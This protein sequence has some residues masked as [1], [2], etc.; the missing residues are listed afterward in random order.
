MDVC[1]AQDQQLPCDKNH[2]ILVSNKSGCEDWAPKDAIGPPGAIVADDQGNVYF[3]SPNIVFKVLADG[4][5]FRFAGNGLP[6]FSGDGGPALDALL[7]FPL[8]Y[9]EM[10]AD[11]Q[12]FPPLV[13]ALAVA[14]NLVY[15]ADAYNN[16]VR[17]VD[18]NGMISTVAGNGSRGAPFWD[19][20]DYGPAKEAPMTWPQGI[21]V[22]FEYGDLYIANAY[23]QLRWIHQGGWILPLAWPNC[24]SGYAAPGLC[25]PGQI[26]VRFPGTSSPTVYIPDR[27]CRVRAIR[28]YGASAG[29]TTVAG[30]EANGAPACGYGGDGGLATR[31]QLNAR[32][33]AVAVDAAGNLFIA[34]SESHCIRKVDAATQMISTVVG[35]CG[36]PSPATPGEAGP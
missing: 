25:A 35:V 28:P 2:Y 15:I 8:V 32:P 13:G 3:S 19:G 22:D 23:G 14:G 11:P 17:V 36:T 18:A 30:A 31:A 33:G 27:Y 12:H 6:G 34:D 26:T 29:V 9:P 20:G 5:V 1:G 10:A 21:A 24:G 16:R 7:N 4:A